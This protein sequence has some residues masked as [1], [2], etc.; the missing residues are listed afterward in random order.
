MRVLSTIGLLLALLGLGVLAYDVGQYAEYGG[1]Q[2]TAVGDLWFSVHAASLNLVQ[3]VIERY[4]WPP[5]WDPLITTILLW[6]AG[7]FYVVIGL[8]AFF[9]A[10]SRIG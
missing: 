4:L 1:F 7:I 2:M 9:S 5:L 6:P 10:K 3:A 8:L